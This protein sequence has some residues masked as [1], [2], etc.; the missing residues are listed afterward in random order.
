MKKKQC[1]FYLSFLKYEL[2][3][4]IFI[5]LKNIFENLKHD[6]MYLLIP[7]WRVMNPLK[8]YLL[9]IKMRN[10]GGVGGSWASF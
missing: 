8:Q 4:F 6:I 3:N 5:E 2:L 7:I 10:K 1:E 9:T